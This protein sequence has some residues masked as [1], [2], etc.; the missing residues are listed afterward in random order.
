[1]SKSSKW[2]DALL[3]SGLPLEHIVADYLVKEN[4]EIT[5]QYSYL[6][7]NELGI[8]TEFSIDI[9][10]FKFISNPKNEDDYIELQILV[11]CKYSHKSVK[12]VFYPHPGESSLVYGYIHCLDE[13]STRKIIDKTFLD[14][15]EK[16][17]YACIKG[18]ALHS[19]DTNNQTI[20]RGLNQLRF[21]VPNI[22][23]KSLKEQYLSFHNSEAHIKITCPIL[24]TTAPIYVLNPNLSL[25][26]IYKA[27]LIDEI[28]EKVGSILIYQDNSP[29]LS[30][31][32]ESRLRNL[33][34]K[35]V[36]IYDRAEKLSSFFS[37]DNYY[38]RDAKYR[39]DESLFRASERILVT[40]LE[41]L[42]NEITEIISS[43]TN[44]FPNIKY[45]ADL[46][47]DNDNRQIH[48]KKI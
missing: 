48:L 43:I 38:S 29:H 8:S 16:N 20:D 27:D 23:E 26:N 35:Y 5:G 3:K 42:E 15:F 39:L 30:E 18:I 36:G 33:S 41:N 13:L 25:E 7:P 6:R 19:N 44:S 40:T 10:A 1:M 31:Y 11:E 46:S 2:K 28:A 9:F 14:S 22:V 4:F 17:K 47:Y 24:I 45:Y 32:S 37:S 34:T 21:A 12:W